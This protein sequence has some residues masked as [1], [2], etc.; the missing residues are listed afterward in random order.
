MR[1][2]LVLALLLLLSPLL[3]R[4]QTPPARSGHQQLQ[5]AQ[6]QLL[7]ASREGQPDAAACRELRRRAEGGQLGSSGPGQ[8]LLLERGRLL[9]E[10]AG[11]QHALFSIELD[12]LCGW[13]ALVLRLPRSHLEPAWQPPS[14]AQATRPTPVDAAPKSNP[15]RSL[16]H[17]IKDRDIALLQWLIGVCCVLLIAGLVLIG[18]RGRPAASVPDEAPTSLLPPLEPPPPFSEQRAE[19]QRLQALVR[20]QLASLQQ[21]VLQMRRRRGA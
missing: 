9:G 17:L 13:S 10:L 19:N 12:G 1:Q 2:A 8:L 6:A 3:G 16:V 18:R 11:P 4:A 7:A 21:Q 20:E 14:A 15:V 5:Q